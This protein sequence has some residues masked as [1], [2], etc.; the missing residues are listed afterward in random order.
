MSCGIALKMVEC[1]MFDKTI[2]ND[3]A[4][5][6]ETPQALTP[7]ERRDL[8]LSVREAGQEVELT[9]LRVLHSAVQELR[10]AGVTQPRIIAWLQV[11][12]RIKRATAYDLLAAMDAICV[13]GLQVETVREAVVGA[14]MI[15][16]ANE[17]GQTKASAIQE[18]QE[19]VNAKQLERRA[20]AKASSDGT[21]RVPL[22][23][24]AM[25]DLE[26]QRRRV[27]EISRKLGLTEAPGAAELTATLIQ[28]VSV[29]PESMLEEALSLLERMR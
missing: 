21:V 7:E 17:R 3:L 20:A 2:F 14:R 29:M 19:A 8:V 27:A 28:V 18:A 15:R 5:V 24:A 11:G 16:T 13:D 4:R 9:G 26:A 25:N 23:E 22:P 12:E 6:L 1:G 10:D